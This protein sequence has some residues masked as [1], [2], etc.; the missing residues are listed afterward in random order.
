[1]KQYGKII[2]NQHK[3][4]MN[5]KATYQYLKVLKQQMAI[6][7]IQMEK[8]QD[9]GLIIKEQTLTHYQM[10]ENKNYKQQALI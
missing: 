6:Q 2:I 10:K 5:I 3:Y 8:N 7:K 9:N 4:I 1:M